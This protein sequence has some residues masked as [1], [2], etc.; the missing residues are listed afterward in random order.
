MP[1]EDKDYAETSICSISTLVVICMTIASPFI[2]VPKNSEFTGA[3]AIIIIA[4]AGGVLLSVILC[5]SAF[6][7]KE[8]LAWLS[9][10][11]LFGA[12]ILVTA[13]TNL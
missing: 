10:L 6:Y 5:I 4:L 3:A 2:L 8:K 7:R 13:T 11:G 9:L 12:F 1:T